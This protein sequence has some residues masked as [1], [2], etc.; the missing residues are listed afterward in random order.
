[1]DIV[2]SMTS[3][4]ATTIAPSVA[5]PPTYQGMI[6]Q[7]NRTDH[8]PD[9]T[10]MFSVLSVETDND[11]AATLSMLVDSGADNHYI[12]PEFQ[13]AINQYIGGVAPLEKP[14]PIETASDGVGYVTPTGVIQGIRTYTSG[15]RVRH[16]L[17]VIIVPKLKRHFF[18]MTRARRAKV[19][20]IM[21]GSP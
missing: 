20:T 19:H 2:S 7:S 3:F 4:A 10:T 16:N 13:P 6:N 12:C 21:D 9:D 8:I 18:S 14:F 17:T 5:P 11:N 15:Q 1:M